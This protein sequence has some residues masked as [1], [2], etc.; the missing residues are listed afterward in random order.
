[1]ERSRAGG[2]LAIAAAR[3]AHRLAQRCCGRPLAP[4]GNIR[5]KALVCGASGQL[6]AALQSR[7]PPNVEL[8]AASRQQLDITDLAALQAKLERERV[9]VVINAA[10]YTDV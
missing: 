10:A 9:S 6:G 5:M 7:V 8:V 3:A 4:R 2:P 1:M